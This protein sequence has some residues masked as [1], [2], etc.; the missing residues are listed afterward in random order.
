[1]ET[2]YVRLKNL[3]FRPEVTLDGNSL[4]PVTKCLFLARSDV[5]LKIRLFR[6]QRLGRRSTEVTSHPVKNYIYVTA[7]KVK[8]HTIHVRQHYFLTRVIS[9][10]VRK[11]LI[12]LE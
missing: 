10:L 9:A 12:A 7:C 3:G 1:M 2:R 6:F 5:V 11:S 4:L 8:V